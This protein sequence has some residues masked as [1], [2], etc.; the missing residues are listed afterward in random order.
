MPDRQLFVNPKRLSELSTPQ[1]V[2][3]RLCQSIDYGQILGLHVRDREPVFHP[4]P[5]LLL[6]IRLGSNYR[7]R[8]ECDLADFAL[9]NEVCRLLD[10][11][12]HIETGRI[13]QIE[14]RAGIPQRLI[15]EV[16]L[17]EATL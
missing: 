16:A 15:V 13:Q 12:R 14:I 2:L 17:T 6:D 5:K 9:C 7:D 3:L 8:S 10:R 11:L 1:R 4:V